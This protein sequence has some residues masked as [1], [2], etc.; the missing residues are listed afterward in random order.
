MDGKKTTNVL[1]FLILIALILN[2]LSSFLPVKPVEAET[3][4]LDNCVTVK[5]SNKPA[6]YLH[7]VAHTPPA[8]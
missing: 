8:E 4:R 6:A 3:F 2:L 1:L 5:K 7:V